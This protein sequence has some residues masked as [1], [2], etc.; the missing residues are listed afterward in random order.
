LDAESF[1][2]LHLNFFDHQ[3]LEDLPAQD[4]ARWELR[5]LLA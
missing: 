4:V 5:V 1:R 2:A 3:A